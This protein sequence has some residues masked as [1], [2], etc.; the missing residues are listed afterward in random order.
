MS[1]PEAESPQRESP[2]SI[3]RKWLPWCL[4][5]IFAMTAGWITLVA[6][7][8]LSGGNRDGIAPTV[9]A[10]VNGAAPAVPL[11]V[12]CAILITSALDFGGGFAVV[13]ARY[14]TEKFLDPWRQKRRE[15][16]AKALEEALE[17]AREESFAQALEELR[18]G[19]LEQAIEEGREQGRAEG[20][21]EGRSEGLAEGRSEGLAEGRSEG[22]A[23][24]RVEERL[25]W[26]GW[27]RRR[28]QAAE[29]GLPFDEPPPES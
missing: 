28:L 5:L 15:E 6:L 10:V 17:K 9:I 12:L 2:L 7:E 14:L 3:A 19:G 16:A 29:Y 4:F 18:A 8:E 1:A 25:K 20:L 23:E 26:T 11:I 13:T 21:A 22:L 27:N 24:G